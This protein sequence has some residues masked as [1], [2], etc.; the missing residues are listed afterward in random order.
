MG[1]E[2]YGGLFSFRLEDGFV[3]SDV[4]HLPFVNSLREACFL[5]WLSW[6][7]VVF[8]FL[9]EIFLIFIKDIVDLYDISVYY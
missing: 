3:L 8:D 1:I 4:S 6:E 7:L 2:V 9:G 5:N